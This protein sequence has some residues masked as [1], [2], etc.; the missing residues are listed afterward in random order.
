MDVFLCLADNR[1]VFLD[2]R[3]N[4]YLCLNQKNT[5]I[6]ISLLTDFTVPQPNSQT[7]ECLTDDEDKRRVVEA[8]TVRGL[9]VPRGTG[10]KEIKPVCILAAARTLVEGMRPKPAIRISHW[11]AFLNASLRATWKLRCFSMQHVAHSVKNRK[12][13]RG[14]PSAMP[15]DALR[16]LV[17][18]FHYLRPFYLRKY[19]CLYDSLALVEFLAVYRSYPQWAFGVTAEPFGAHCWVQEHDLVLNDT[20]ERVTRYTPIM[21]I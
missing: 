13:R 1:L 10:G 16:E 9:C 4:Q 14:R 8:L 7:D 11:T 21:I 3:L 6:A 2:L 15:H 20:V 18:I 17:A 19:L 12:S 5:Q